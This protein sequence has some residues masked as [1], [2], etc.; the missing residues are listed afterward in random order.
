MARQ[1]G[2]EAMMG[3]VWIVI[4][5]CLGPACQDH[6][7]VVGAFEC[8]MRGQSIGIE[9]I[10]ENR[11]KWRFHAWRCEPLGRGQEI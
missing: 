4:T 3:H 6:R 1:Q 9:W 2:P 10:A 8:M 7:E 5:F 11:P